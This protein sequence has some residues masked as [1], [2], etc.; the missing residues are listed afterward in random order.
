MQALAFGG[1]VLAL[2]VATKQPE[3]GSGALGGVVQ[4]GR[5]TL[6]Q[7]DAGNGDRID[8]GAIGSSV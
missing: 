1:G 4:A 3:A 5:Q 8:D 2:V 7:E 6:V